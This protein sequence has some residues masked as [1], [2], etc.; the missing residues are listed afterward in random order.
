[1]KKLNLYIFF[2]LVILLLNYNS[3]KSFARY[4]SNIDIVANSTTGGMICSATISDSG[5]DSSDGYAYFDVT[6]SNNQN[7]ELT[8]TYVK[9]YIQVKDNANSANAGLYR[10]NDNNNNGVSSFSS[11]VK[12]IN[13]YFGNTTNE[14]NTIRF[15]VDVAEY[16]AADVSSDVIVNCEQTDE[17]RQE[18]LPYLL[19]DANLTGSSSDNYTEGNMHEMYP[20]THLATDQMKAT[21]DYRYIGNDPYNYVY[22][23]CTDLNNQNAS[24]CEI[25]RIIGLFEVDNGTGIYERRYKLT[26]NTLLPQKKIYNSSGR[27]SFANSTL[28]NY[29]NTTYYNS[30]TSSSKEMISD[31]KYYLGG[32]D[33][34]YFSTEE[35]YTFERSNV[36]Y[37]GN[38]TY[39]VGKIGIIYPSDQFFI[40]G[41]G[42]ESEC[43]NQMSRYSS[44][45]ATKASHGWMYNGN[46]LE[47]DSNH[48]KII[49]S[50]LTPHGVPGI[51]HRIKNTTSTASYGNVSY[52][53]DGDGIRP[54]L[55]LSPDVSFESGDGSID[56]PYKLRI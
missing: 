46:Y 34:E 19:I 45:D 55:Y 30:L 20:F 4:K 18:A 50:T 43:F 56:N 11:N 47:G 41:K 17:L 15:K 16:T 53:G 1:M 28:E 31:A 49:V 33:L 25:W 35:S 48:T 6:V 7:N 52:S 54:V 37:P 2:I 13:Y 9:Y 44:C 23:N 21:T 39:W 24:T 29:L 26:T 8:K 5:V 22:F 51:D 12:T 27:S 3:N 40:Y 38:T 32:S 36:V 14:S 42:V 10:W